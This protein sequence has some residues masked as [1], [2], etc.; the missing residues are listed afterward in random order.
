MRRPISLRQAAVAGIVGT[1][2]IT[3]TAMLVGGFWLLRRAEA[4]LQESFF[5]NLNH[6]IG[7]R[8]NVHFR[9]GRSLLEEFVH[10]AQI[11]LLPLDDHDVLGTY[12][13]ER[14]RHLAGFAWISWSSEQDGRFVGARRRDD[15]V[16]ILNMSDPRVAGGNPS[17]WIVHPDG[18]REPIAADFP[19]YDPRVRPWY[20]TASERTNIIWTSAVQFHEG[21]EG[22]TMA[23]ALHDADGRRVGVFTID[24]F[25]EQIADFLETLRVGRAGFCFILHVDGALILPTGLPPLARTAPSAA[26]RS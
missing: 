13:A 16:I 26:I 25:T 7:E 20:R 19:P 14:L 3:A 9:S 4:R 22:V 6:S 18:T 10:R 11:G 8:A 17:E 12:I 23:C 21:R 24:L 1:I 5:A 15:G 2:V